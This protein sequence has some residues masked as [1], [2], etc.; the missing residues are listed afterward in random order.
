[1]SV[2]SKML[3]LGWR[4]DHL[5]VPVAVWRDQ[6]DCPLCGY[7]GHFV[8]DW[9]LTGV[10]ANAMCP[11]CHSSERHRIQWAVINRLSDRYDF[12]Q[13]SLLHISPE[14]FNGEEL[15]LLFKEYTTA[16]YDGIGA[17]LQIDLTDCDLPDESY[18]VIY[19][20][21][22][23][24]HIPDDRAAAETVR[25]LLKPG[26]FAVLPVPIVCEET[27]EYP[28]VVMTEFGHVRGPGPE[29]FDRFEDLF[30]IELFTSADVSDEIQPWIFEDRSRYPT[31]WAPYRTPSTGKRHADVVPVLKRP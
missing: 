15:K 13:M 12:S 17:D 24:E 11:Q 27:V 7:R 26:G 25:R 16:D 14:S 20:S 18:D 22:V 8:S 28:E 19:A 10:R 31:K 9:E 4:V 23:L 2:Y 29:Y 5:I 3:A 21:H 30:E 1:L 6:Y